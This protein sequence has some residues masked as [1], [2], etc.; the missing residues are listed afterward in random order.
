[1]GQQVNIYQKEEES[2]SIG[3]IS[4]RESWSYSSYN[5]TTRVGVI[6]VPTNA[7]LKYTVGWR[8]KIT[9]STGGTKYGIIHAVSSTT[10]TVFFP[11]GVTFNNESITDNFYSMVKAPFGF[12]IDPA[13][14]SRTTTF[15]T[16]RTFNSASWTTL[17]DS[18]DL[19][20]GAWNVWHK[21]T[22]ICDASAVSQRILQVTL[23][24]TTTTETYPEL[25]L[26]QTH[27]G[28]T[29]ASSANSGT[30]SAST[31]IKLASP[32]T[33]TLLGILNS[34]ANINNVGVLNSTN[35]N[36]NVRAVSAYL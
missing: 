16:D 33:L 4:A 14:W 35:S 28:E 18:I 10:L 15:T 25:T 24:N 34:T 21:Q 3:W 27:D 26:C 11:T 22:M 2:P 23:S 7:T 29:T 32:A 13:V 8:I 20:I 31:L 17:T 5:S 6:T 30:A 12:D 36:G 1:M 19:G 9:Q